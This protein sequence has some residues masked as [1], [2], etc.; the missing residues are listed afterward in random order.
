M[1]SQLNVYEEKMEKSID[2]LLEEFSTIRAGRANPNIIKNVTVE[3]Y[4]VPTP[5]AQVGN[6]TV[7]EAR[8]LQI[9]PWDANVLKDLEKALNEADLGI[10]PSNDGK[11]V[12]LIFPELTEERRKELTKEVKKR[13]EEAKITIR[14][15]RREALDFYK[16]AEANKEISEDILKDLEVDVQDLTDKYVAKVDENVEIKSEDILSV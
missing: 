16:K 6:I 5:I 1:K 2:A 13:G 11:V 9:Q 14:N 15:I 3:Y 10:N 8:I 12:R 7:P 4:G